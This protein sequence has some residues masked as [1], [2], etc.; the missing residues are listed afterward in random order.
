LGNQ[1]CGLG[2]ILEETIILW[3]GEGGGTK[4]KNH[5]SDFDILRS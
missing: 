3:E 5:L 2:K 1:N 4:I